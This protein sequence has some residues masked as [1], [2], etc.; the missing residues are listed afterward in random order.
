[1]ARLHPSTTAVRVEGDGV[2]DEW[3]L[4]PFSA[5]KK[6]SSH[7]QKFLC[8]DMSRILVTGVDVSSERAPWLVLNS[9]GYYWHEVSVIV[10]VTPVMAKWMRRHVES[11]D[12]LDVPAPL[13]AGGQDEDRLVC[14][15]IRSA[16]STVHIENQVWISGPVF[17]NRISATLVDRLCRDVRESGSFRC[18]LLTNISQEDEPSGATRW[19]C[20]N[21]VRWS[22]ASVFSACAERGVLAEQVL[23]RLCVAS[24][25]SG[26]CP[27]KIHSNLVIADGE[28]LLRSSSNLLD[29]SI[30][31]R[32]DSE[33]G[34]GV[35]GECVG[36]LQRELFRRYLEL[37]AEEP[38]SIHD[39]FRGCDEGAGLLRPLAGRPSPALWALD[40]KMRLAAFVAPSI[41]GLGRSPRWR[42]T[43]EHGGSATRARTEEHACKGWAPTQHIFR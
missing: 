37:G 7:H 38:V 23:E 4:A 5:N 21:G 29:R 39:F 12:L 2:V 42:S 18:L 26:E 11:L 10:G 14:D 8:I 32:S 1:V 9:R 34:V 19:F 28:R 24:L 25:G 17:N 36:N 43:A 35:E 16:E 22:Y 27:I 31:S 13:V 15:M 6:W 30:W 3:W 33:L 20:R 41:L 40:L